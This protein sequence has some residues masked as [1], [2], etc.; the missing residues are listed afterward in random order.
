M[1]AVC[2]SLRALSYPIRENDF[3]QPSDSRT[4]STLLY[5]YG[6]HPDNHFRGFPLGRYLY[7]RN[8]LQSH[9]QHHDYLVYPDFSA[10]LVFFSPSLRQP[11]TLDC[12]SR[13]YA[14][15][16]YLDDLIREEKYFTTS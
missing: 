15:K 1:R 10:T 3:R 12:F 14:R 16:R 6:A 5:L 8:S 2:H 4:N 13:F 11:R 7:R 9:P